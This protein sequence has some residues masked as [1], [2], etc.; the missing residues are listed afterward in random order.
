MF[1]HQTL[2]RGGFRNWIRTMIGQTLS[3]QEALRIVA[4]NTLTRM[5]LPR[6]AFWIPLAKLWTIDRGFSAL[7][8]RMQVRLFS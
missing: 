5:L 6:W 3:V 7:E 4:Q 2:E 1:K 8:K